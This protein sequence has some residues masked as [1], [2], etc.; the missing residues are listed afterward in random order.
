MQSRVSAISCVLY[1]LEV[2]DEL[3]I[4]V[5]RLAELRL[6]KEGVES[7]FHQQE[8]QLAALQEE[9]RRVSE[10]TPQTDTVY[11]R[12]TPTDCVQMEVF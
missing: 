4:I 10:S 2:M 1:H 9:L 6:E 8:D 3:I 5:F 11:A 7:R 12:A